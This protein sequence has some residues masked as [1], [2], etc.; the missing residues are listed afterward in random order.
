[1][2]LTDAERVA[3][4]RFCGFP[5]HTPY[6]TTALQDFGNLETIM[7]RLSDAEQA[8]VRTEYLDVLPGLQTAVTG[9]GDNLDTDQAAVWHRNRTEVSDRLSLFRT[10]CRELCM[11]LG[12]TP[13]PGLRAAG[14]LIR[15]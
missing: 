14:S 15:T 2:A 13:G 10:K 5:V 1:M 11:F 9:A 3:V 4:R 8:V 6:G 12:V 7:T